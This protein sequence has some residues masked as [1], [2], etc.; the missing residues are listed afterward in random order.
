MTKLLWAFLLFN[1][2]LLSVFSPLFISF[3][4]AF[5]VLVSFLLSFWPSFTLSVC[6]FY[7][8]FCISIF[9]STIPSISNNVSLLYD[10]LY[11]FTFFSFLSL[12]HLSF[13]RSRFKSVLWKFHLCFFLSYRFYMVIPFF[14]SGPL[15]LGP[16]SL[17][18][19][20]LLFV[21][22]VNLDFSHVRTFIFLFKQFYIC[23]W[24]N[25]FFLSVNVNLSLL[26]FLFTVFFLYFYILSFFPLLSIILVIFLSFSVLFSFFLLF[27]FS[28]LR[29]AFVTSN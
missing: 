22:T 14:L 3:R 11:F 20:V 15:S 23:F 28:S 1:F 17:S 8:Y 9:L 24:N 29:L 27:S 18:I 6:H 10:I 16:F 21:S 5:S 12:I 19:F 13:C 26:Y 4:N 7:L 25:L 2:V